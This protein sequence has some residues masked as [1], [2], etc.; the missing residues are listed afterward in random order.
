MLLL[1]CWR[2]VSLATASTW[3]PNEVSSTVRHLQ[4]PQRIIFAGSFEHCDCTAP[5]QH[6]DQQLE[7]VVVCSAGDLGGSDISSDETLPFLQDI[8]RTCRH[9]CVKLF[10]L[11]LIGDLEPDAVR[12]S[13]GACMHLLRCIA[14]CK[15]MY[16][17]PAD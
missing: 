8:H 7:V 4:L 5:T 9:C 13:S 12:G 10:T 14:A 6:T 3:Y 11:G 17:H 2:R 1:G 15:V 16:T